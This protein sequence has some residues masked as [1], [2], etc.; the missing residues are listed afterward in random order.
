[1]NL[2]ELRNEA[3][4]MADDRAASPLYDDDFMDRTANE[5]EREACI[6]A[7]LIF[8]DSSAFLRHAL[9]A[10][11]SPLLILDERVDVLEYATF[12]PSVGTAYQLPVKDLAH[13]RRVDEAYSR[14][15]RPELIVRLSKRQARVW[16]APGAATVGTIQLGTYRLPLADMEQDTDEP[17]IA[18]EHHVGLVHWMLYK[19]FWTKD[20]DEGDEKR[21]GEHE[22]AFTKLF[23][24]KRDANT[25]RTQAERRKPVAPYGGL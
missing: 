6:R 24:P 21:A 15:G 8:D 9:T 11:G 5:A 1:M 10:S 3:R 17:E 7:R 16:P 13:V 23:G 14:T 12:T 25:Y 18:L 22:A 19:A 4:R 20:G 2:E